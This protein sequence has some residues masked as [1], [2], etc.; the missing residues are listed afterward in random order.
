MQVRSVITTHSS[1]LVPEAPMG[2]FEPPKFKNDYLGV[3]VSDETIKKDR[4]WIENEINAAE[5]LYKILVDEITEANDDPSDI[6]TPSNF[7]YDAKTWVDWFDDYKRGK[8]MEFKNKW[9]KELDYED[10]LRKR[11]QD[12]WCRTEEERIAAY[13]E[14]ERQVAAGELVLPTPP[15]PEFEEDRAE[16]RKWMN[17]K[18]VCYFGLLTEIHKALCIELPNVHIDWSKE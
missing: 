3:R 15:G 5:E 4:Q 8:L 16:Y 11:K 17:S 12:Y 6:P 7:M 10:Y 2:T 9:Q 1:E 13:E 14:E 18:L